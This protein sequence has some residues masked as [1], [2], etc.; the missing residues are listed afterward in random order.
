MMERI[1]SLETQ[2]A[3]LEKSINALETGHRDLWNTIS[4]I[5]GEVSRVKVDV[6]KVVAVVGI[7]QIIATGVIVY[8]ITRS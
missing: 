3:V 5:R 6:A 8:S 7:I 1:H 4:D 2:Q